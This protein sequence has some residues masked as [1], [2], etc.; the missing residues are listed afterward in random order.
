MVHTLENSQVVLPKVKTEISHDPK[1][2]LQEYVLF[3]THP[4]EIKTYVHTKTCI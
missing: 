1:I 3:D 2:L 4:R